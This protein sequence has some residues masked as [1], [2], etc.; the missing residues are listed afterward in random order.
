MGE[1]AKQRDAIEACRIKTAKVAICRSDTADRL[2]RLVIDQSATHLVQRQERAERER[3]QTQNVCISQKFE[4]MEELELEWVERLQESR[5]ELEQVLLQTRN[6]LGPHVPA[7][8]VHNKCY[9]PIASLSLTSP[10]LSIDGS[11]ALSS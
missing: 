2:D 10:R 3:K 1:K 9:S 5:A 8:S 11:M 7:L 6:R 4:Q